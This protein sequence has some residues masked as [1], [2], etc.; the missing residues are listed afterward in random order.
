V[1]VL[2]SGP[3]PIADVLEVELPRPR[4]RSDPHLIAFYDRVWPTL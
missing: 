1:V 3:G 2:A 4:Q